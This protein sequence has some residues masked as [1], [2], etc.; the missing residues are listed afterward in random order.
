MPKEIDCP[1][2]DGEQQETERLESDDYSTPC[3]L[4][5]GTGKVVASDARREALERAI[6][7][8]DPD[9]DLREPV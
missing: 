8:R 2:C 5:N 9:N 3:H 4:C 6:A 7:E 1:E